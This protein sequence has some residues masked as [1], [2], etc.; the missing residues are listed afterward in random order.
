MVGHFV[1]TLSPEEED[2]V[3]ESKLSVGTFKL[4]ADGSRCL[5]AAAYPPS[6]D[7]IYFSEPRLTS[8]SAWG[9][10]TLYLED[11]FDCLCDR[12]GIVR[13]A[14]LVRNRILSNRARRTL[15]AVPTMAHV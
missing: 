5:I 15:H 13:I 8:W 9:N 14:A 6:G 4:G 7:R 10:R 12:F 1:N 3:L 2:R 11:R